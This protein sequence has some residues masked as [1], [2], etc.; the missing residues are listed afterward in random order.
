MRFI[1]KLPVVLWG[2]ECA[3]S[4]RVVDAGGS[5][6]QLPLFLPVSAAPP[7]DSAVSLAE[8]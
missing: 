3:V 1:L 4:G 5:I 2:R 7:P 6:R 8:R